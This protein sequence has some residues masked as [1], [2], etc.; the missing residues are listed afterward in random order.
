M[1]DIT[2]G[3]KS[4]QRII[5]CAAELFLTNGYNNTGISEIL[6]VT[7][8]PKGSFYY[9]FD[10][11]KQLAVEVAGYF[12]DKV[13]SWLLEISFNRTWCDFVEV[14]MNQIISDAKENHYFG[15]PFAVI[16]SETAFVD[17]EIADSF[18]SPL[19][20]LI[21]IFMKVLEVSD[22]PKE[23]LQSKAKHAFALFEGYILY[24][25]VTKEVEILEILK[26]QLL[27][28]KTN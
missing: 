7:N 23:E 4:K 13:G 24:Y 19:K 22:I 11:K 14:F 10:S 16:G 3:E 5:E 17:P 12:K 28:I 20:N 27:E 15:C 8:L 2:K 26:E 21:H 1:V 6:A 18:S 9:H 25:R